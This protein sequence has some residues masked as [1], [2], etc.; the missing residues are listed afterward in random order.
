VHTGVEIPISPVVGVDFRGRS[1]LPHEF[2]VEIT[3]DFGHAFLFFFVESLHA[4]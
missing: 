4:G 2:A 1:L 3:L